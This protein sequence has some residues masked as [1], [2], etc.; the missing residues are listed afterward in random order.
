[1]R[2][3]GRV[4][5]VPL[6]GPLHEELVRLLSGLSAADWERPTVAGAWRMRDVAA[7]ILDTDLRRI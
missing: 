7:H 4:N 2:E 6:F 3:P 1:M 5:V